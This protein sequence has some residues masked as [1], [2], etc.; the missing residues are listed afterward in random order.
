[1]TDVTRRFLLA[2]IDHDEL[3]ALLELRYRTC[4]RVSER[5]IA[6]PA[7]HEYKL[8]VNMRHGQ[9][10]SISSGNSLSE[11]E[12]QEILQ[13]VEAELTD[14]RIVEYGA[15]ILFAHRP[16]KG[17]F[18]FKS[19]PIQILPPSPDAPQENVAS[20]HPFVIEYPITAY[21]TSEVRFLRR[22]KCAIEWAWVLNAL[23]HGS[24][25]YVTSRLRQM[26]AIK[27]GDADARCFWAQEF[28]IHPGFQGFT[29]ELSVEG[30]PLTVVG[31]DEYYGGPE[32][33]AN[34]PI[35][36]FF[37]PD[38]LDQL[39]AAYLSLDA[40]KRRRFLRSAAAI[41]IARELWELSISSSFLA[42]VQAIETLVDR[43]PPDPCPTCHKDRGPGPT[44]LFQD[45]V[46][47]H[48]GMSDVGEAVKHEL[49]RTRS[50]LAHGRYLFQLDEAPWA[51]NVAATIA[52]DYE[53]E[54]ARSAL[55]VSK[56]ALRNWL[57]AQ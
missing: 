47:G 45:F 56:D 14:H 39:V 36:T 50:D 11:Q 7:V 55:I 37:L 16:V 26:W 31:A 44:K 17:A 3:L 21:K 57:L 6:F 22:R 51:F 9:I 33:Q 38:N 5:A 25:R 41:Y 2:N 40:D 12:L 35:D 27:S 29:S 10:T 24:I 18:R 19:V 8:R 30:A 49:Y 48:C 46:E 23:L 20:A 13:Q 32:K 1:L 54:L 15:E 43:P 4:W 52:S 34:F 28:Y 42:C 53:L